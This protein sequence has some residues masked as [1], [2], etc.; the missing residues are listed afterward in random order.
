MV[1]SVPNIKKLQGYRNYYRV[2]LGDFRRGFA[3]DDTLA[4]PALRLLRLLHRREIY[5]Y[6]P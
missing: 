2:R 3:L 4:G 6:F 5:R 1:A